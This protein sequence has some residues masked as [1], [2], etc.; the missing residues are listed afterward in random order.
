MFYLKDFYLT[1]WIKLLLAWRNRSSPHVF[2]MM[3]MCAREMS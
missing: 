2:V 1:H 3:L